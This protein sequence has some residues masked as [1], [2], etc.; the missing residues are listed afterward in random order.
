MTAIAGYTKFIIHHGGIEQS[1]FALG[2]GRPQILPN[3]MEQHMNATN[4]MR[5][6]SA[7]VKILAKIGS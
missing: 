6:S 7:G 2:L 1:Q 5:L 3:H 4:L